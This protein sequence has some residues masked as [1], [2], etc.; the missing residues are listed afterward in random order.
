MKKMGSNARTSTREKLVIPTLLA[1]VL[2]ALVLFEVLPSSQDIY[3][4]RA[5]IEEL[6]AD[7]QEQKTLLP[8]YL[9]LRQ[10]QKKALPEGISVNELQPLKIE[11]LAELPKVFETL[12]RASDL[13]L[14]SVTPQVR[15]LQNGRE[16]L[17]IDARMRGEFLT[18]NILLNRLNEMRFVESIE[19][20]TIEVTGLGQEM[21]LSV[22]LAIQ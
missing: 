5:S 15:S 3:K 4:A 16:M 14:V 7:L 18:F 11:A 1:M 22:W 19:S 12:A 2:F 8:I 20:L 13:E 21:N 9:S 6:Q 10:S 17:R